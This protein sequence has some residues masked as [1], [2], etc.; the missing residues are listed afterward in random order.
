MR[1]RRRRRPC[2][3][4]R[5]RGLDRRRELTAMDPGA[6]ELVGIVLAVSAVAAVAAASVLLCRT[7][8]RDLSLA[9]SRPALPRRVWHHPRPTERLGPARPLR[10]APTA[11]TPVV[12]RARPHPR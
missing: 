12:A 10:P 7:R 3:R 4:G 9:T 5:R 1:S 11:P 8:R 2:R 6:G